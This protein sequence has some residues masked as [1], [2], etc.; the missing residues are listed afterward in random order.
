M[1]RV[2]VRAAESVVLEVVSGYYSTGA[3]LDKRVRSMSGLCLEHASCS[4]KR[5]QY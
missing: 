4:A 3:P 2:E 1:V 5:S